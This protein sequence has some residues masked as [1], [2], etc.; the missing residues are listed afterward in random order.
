VN[1]EENFVDPITGCCTNTIEGTWNGMKIQIPSVHRTRKFVKGELALFCWKRRY[2]NAAWSRLLHVLKT[3]RYD[4]K[5][6]Y[7]TY[8]V[9]DENEETNDNAINYVETLDI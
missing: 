1:H 8:R 5:N 6:M 2:G 7:T 3:T 9:G 4:P